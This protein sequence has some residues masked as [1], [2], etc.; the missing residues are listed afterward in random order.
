MLPG[1]DGFNAFAAKVH[2]DLAATNKREQDSP[3]KEKEHNGH[4]TAIEDAQHPTVVDFG[5]PPTKDA[6]GMTSS[7][8][9]LGSTTTKAVQEFLQWHECLGHLVPWRIK[10][11][12]TASILPKHLANCPTLHCATC[13]YGKAMRQP[14]RHKPTIATCIKQGPQAPGNCMSMDQLISCTPGLIDLMQG[15]TKSCYQ[16][17]TV[18]VDQFTRLSYVHL[19]QSTLAKETS[20][21]KQAFEH[22]SKRH[23]V[24]IRHYHANNGIFANTKF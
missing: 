12:A 1:Y 14:W 21:A 5:L 10:A 2:K 19:Q 24:T 15:M 13:L 16:A 22:F 23:S 8:E 17:A 3:S 9:A 11:L 6:L 18:F 4:I 20:E 7:I